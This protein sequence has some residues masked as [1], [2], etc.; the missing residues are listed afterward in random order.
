MCDILLIINSII[1]KIFPG[2]EN[3]DQNILEIMLQSRWNGSS[4][5]ARHSKVLFCGSSGLEK[6]ILSICCCVRNLKG[7]TYLQ[8]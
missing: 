3:L 4:I 1:S 7:T 8:A 6:P 5:K 2:D